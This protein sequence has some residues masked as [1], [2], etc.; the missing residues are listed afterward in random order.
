MPAWDLSADPQPKAA[1]ARAG[2][3][4]PTSRI[5]PRSSE[6][7]TT[8]T[9]LRLPENQGHSLALTVLCVPYSLDSEGGAGLGL[10]VEGLGFGV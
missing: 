2:T 7:G 3:L 6:E 4:P 8:Y 9:V 5:S 10:R 1:P